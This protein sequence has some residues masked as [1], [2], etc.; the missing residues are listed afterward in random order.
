MDFNK[1]EQIKTPL[2]NIGEQS[3]ESDKD[4]EPLK[5]S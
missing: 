3:D 1:E 5:T 2:L 4:T